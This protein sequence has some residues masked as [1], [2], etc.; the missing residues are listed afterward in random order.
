ME[1][2]DGKTKQDDIRKY[3][4]IAAGILL[5]LIVWFVFFHHMTSGKKVA[6]DLGVVLVSEEAFHDNI[7]SELESMLER[8]VGDRNGD[9]KSH[10]S[11]DYLRIT[12]YSAAMKIDSE[13]AEEYLAK[14]Q[15]GSEEAVPEQKYR[16]LTV[17]D[18]ANRLLVDLSSGEYSLFLLSD[19]PLGNFR[20]AASTYGQQGYF[21]ELPEALQSD[22]SPELRDLSRAPFWSELGLEDISF[23]GGVLED[24]KDSDIALEVLGLLQDAHLTIWRE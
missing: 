2:Y 12:D 24:C 13:A 1:R 4:L 5:L 8:L 21:M 22:A 23:F 20:G 15:A 3:T 10:V 14:I 9:G 18:D 16:G 19:Q 11:V 6:P 17:D 7:K